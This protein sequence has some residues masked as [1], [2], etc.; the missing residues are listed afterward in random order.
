MEK[1]MRDPYD[2]LGVPRTA[3]DDEIKKAYRKLAKKYHPDVNKEVG[4]EEKFKEVQNAY[5]TIMNRNANPRSSFSQS[6]YQN[7][8]EDSSL[9]QQIIQDLNMG[10]YMNAYQRLLMI[11]D[12][13]ADWYYFFAIA[14]YGMGNII[15]AKDAI[16]TACQ[17]NPQNVEYRNLY[18]QLHASQQAY[19]Y[20][21][22]TFNPMTCCC[23]LII[24]LQCYSC[25]PCFCCC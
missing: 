1:K 12:R 14:N 17:M 23:Q 11:Q 10:M 22:S 8:Y 13:G 16:A 21:S 9:Y 5:D 24:C 4:A 6:T 15:A 20:R 25:F 7:A 3:S 19:T 2:V 18:N